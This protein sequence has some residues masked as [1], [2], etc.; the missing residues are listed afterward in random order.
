[1]KKRILAFIMAGT[2][3]FGAFALSGCEKEKAKD[4]EKNTETQS[5]T[6]SDSASESQSTKTTKK[7]NSTLSTHDVKYYHI[8]K[9]TK[10][11]WEGDVSYAEA[12]FVRQNKD[13][14]VDP[15]QLL[16]PIDEVVSVRDSKLEKLYKEGKD[17]E[18]TD[19]GKLVIL[20][21]GSIPVLAYNDYFFEFSTSEF[22]KDNL[23]TK[24]PAANRPGYGYIR[25]EQESSTNPGMSQWT[26]AVTYT[27]KGD[28]GITPPE[29]KSDKFAKVIEKI[30]NGEDIK[31]ASLGDS[32]TFGWSSSQR[33]NMA[34]FCPSY[35]NIVRDYIN[36]TFRINAQNANLA[37]SG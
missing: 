19:D 24:F 22:E 31:I 1:M 37:V 34:P 26:L 30:N 12:A 23:A 36:G 10:P 27:H 20:E 8:K 14:V 7:T 13:G 28:S 17:Y 2:M 3:L 18:I 32:I 11:V 21:G 9:F 33:A 15:I 25:S 4:T 5:E 6:A 35:T 29:G 16:Y